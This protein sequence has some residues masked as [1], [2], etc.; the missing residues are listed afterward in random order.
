MS[1]WSDKTICRLIG[2]EHPYSQHTKYLQEAKRRELIC[3]NGKIAGYENTNNKA[4]KISICDSKN[5]K[6]CTKQQICSRATYFNSARH[7]RF[8]GTSGIAKIYKSEAQSRGYNCSVSINKRIETCSSDP[9]ICTDIILC[10]WATTSNNGQIIWKSEAKYDSYITEAEKRKLSC[11]V[12]EP[13]KKTT[14]PKVK[15]KLI[16]SNSSQQESK[17]VDSTPKQSGN[18]NYETINFTN[19]SFYYGEVSNSLPHGLGTL[20]QKNKVLFNGKWLN[21]TSENQEFSVAPRKS[22]HKVAKTANKPP[23]EL[24]D[25]NTSNPTA[26]ATG[27]TTSKSKGSEP[28]S[29]SALNCPATELCEWATHYNG[30]NKVWWGSNTKYGPYVTE[31]KNRKLTCGISM[32]SANKTPQL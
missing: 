11:N 31:A 16:S 22:S 26:N 21:G 27:S 23:V 6:D 25:K 19:D 32:S 20:Y 1:G 24:K 9:A 18:N 30:E 8:W 10:R 5:L 29:S 14:K 12:N 7:T 13:I 3:N 17:P 2:E 28:C 4:K 15:E